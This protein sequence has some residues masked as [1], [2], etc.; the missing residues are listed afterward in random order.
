[1]K[2]E[3]KTDTG[4]DPYIMLAR[5]EWGIEAA[6]RA[7]F[8]DCTPVAIILKRLLEEETD[9]EVVI[10]GGRFQ[11]DEDTEFD[12]TWLLVDGEIVDPTVDQFYSDLDVDETDDLTDRYLTS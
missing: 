2:H 7:E 1:M 12:H 11:C 10:V 4:L 3:S 5:E 8:G 6:E 9:K